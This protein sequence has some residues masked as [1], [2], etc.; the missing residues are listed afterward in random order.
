[1]SAVE[2]TFFPNGPF[3]SVSILFLW[4]PPSFLAFHFVFSA[5]GRGGGKNKIDG[6]NGRWGKNEEVRVMSIGEF[7]NPGMIFWNFLGL[8]STALLCLEL[9]PTTH[10]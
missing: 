4:S 3:V 1:M 7:E 2:K 5:E 9:P 6:E 8:F 10:T